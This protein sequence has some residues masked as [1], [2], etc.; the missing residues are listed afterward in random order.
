MRAGK[1]RK[2]TQRLKNRIIL[3]AVIALST[4]SLITYITSATYTDLLNAVDVLSR[5]DKNL[6]LSKKLLSDLSLA[7]NSLRTYVLTKKKADYRQFNETIDKIQLDIDSLLL[8]QNQSSSLDSIGELLTIQEG[9]LRKFAHSPPG[10]L[11]EYSQKTISKLEK[12]PADSMITSYYTEIKSTTKQIKD[13]VLLVPQGPFDEKAKGFFQKLKALLRKNKSIN[14]DTL[15][16]ISTNSLIIND[17]TTLIRNDSAVLSMVKEI[18]MDIKK[19]ELAAFNK[20]KELELAFIERNTAIIDNIRDII[21]RSE[22]DQNEKAQSSKVNAKGLVKI[23]LTVIKGIIICL[24]I[25]LIIIVI[26]IFADLSKS[27]FYQ[28]RLELAKTKAERLAKIKQQFLSNMSHEIRTP[29]TAIV[30]YTNLLAEN[31]HI[32]DRNIE[33][34]K[35]ASNHLLSLVNDILDMSKIESTGL[36][37]KKASFDLQKLLKQSCDTFQ[38]MANEKAVQVIYQPEK[39]TPVYV[40]ADEVRLKQVIYNLLDNA[41]K[42]TPQGNVKLTFKTIEIGSKVECYIDIS[43]TGVGIP[44]GE[45]RHIFTD[46]YQTD[47][48]H[49]K[50]FKGTGLGLAISKKLVGLHGGDIHVRST[51]GAGSTFSLFLPLEQG[52]ELALS[53]HKE[54]IAH[55]EFAGM[56]VLV[57][58]DDAFNLELLQELFSHKQIEVDLVSS[59]YEALQKLKTKSYHSL[60]S[61]IHMPGLDGI[62]ILKEIEDL[63]PDMK[64]IALTADVTT[65]FKQYGFYATVT[66]PI[67]PV[68]LFSALLQREPKDNQTSALNTYPSGLYDLS[69]I[70]VFANNEPGAV[71]AILE[72]FI[73]TVSSD[74]KLIRQHVNQNNWIALAERAHKMVAPCAQLKS[75]RLVNAL[76]RL[77]SQEWQSIHDL[78]LIV[79]DVASL[80]ETL[81]ELLKSEIAGLS[82]ENKVKAF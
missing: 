61:D 68:E 43:D 33:I 34:I 74:L 73:E 46:F 15:S 60:I 64:R 53:Q 38:F 80:I 4:F 2:S 59:G 27:K 3:L 13:T 9:H 42:F 39:R 40:Q 23:S 50:V 69:D 17:T 35:S 57:V 55:E 30:G 14:P 76:S 67:N 36:T 16:S 54:P 22:L 7:E 6:E 79:A 77:E 26:L 75:E 21:S 12:N 78:E 81:N 1:H 31:R 37:L 41:I 63:Y 65:K 45:L 56:T 72:A 20:Q 82:K 8:A 51:L 32:T 71:K 62:T 28:K 5:P 19:Q 70:Y 47:N 18:L 52:E 24:T 29:L 66:K 10:N 11:L 48:G 58:D 44:E 49:S 25:I